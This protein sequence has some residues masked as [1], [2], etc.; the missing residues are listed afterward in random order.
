MAESLIHATAIV[1]SGAKLGAGV[2]IGPY[3]IVGENVTLGDEIEL[4]SHAVVAGRTTIGPRTRIF[5]FASIG[6]QP[7]DLKYHGEPSTLVIGSDCMIRESVTMN[8]G[9]EGGGLQTVVGDRCV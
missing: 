4:V 2:K 5:P 7:Q 9:P 1:E 8:P 3:C 6:H